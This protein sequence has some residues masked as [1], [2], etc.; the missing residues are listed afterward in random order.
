M[1]LDACED[2]EK[3]FRVT[4]SEDC[5]GQQARV[6][7]DMLGVCEGWIYKLNEPCSV[8]V[9]GVG[10]LGGT[11]AIRFLHECV[12]S[13]P[14]L[15]DLYTIRTGEGCVRYEPSGDVLRGTVEFMTHIMMHHNVDLLLELRHNSV[16][17]FGAVVERRLQKRTLEA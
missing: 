3:P 17:R 12:A 7:A 5:T 11:D 8:H 1:L 4:W 16:A 14:G 13:L 2:T 15:E 10:I 6:V 9:K